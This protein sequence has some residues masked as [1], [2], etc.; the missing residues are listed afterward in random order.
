MIGSIFHRA[1]NQIFLTAIFCI[2]VVSCVKE[3]VVGEPV[4][5]IPLEVPGKASLLLPENNTACE[6]GEVI[7]NKASVTFSWETGE[8]TEVF[9]LYITNSDTEQVTSRT[10]LATTTA[11]V[12]LVRGHHYSWSVTSMNK[13]L[14]V[15][16]S[17]TYKFY[18]ASDGEENGAPFTAEAVFPSPGSSINIPTNGK[19]VLEWDAA[20]PDNDP[21]TYTLLIDTIDG[22]QGASEENSNL[23][24]R[25]KEI[26]VETGK[27]YYWSI[28]TNDGNIKVNSDIFSFRVK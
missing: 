15:T 10:S 24:E 23:N 26:D 19:I 4:E 21:L 16:E 12:P 2:L 25:F 6:T 11:T 13:G 18:L 3:N 7:G 28:I 27:I 9:D 14:E 22:K 8:N 5:E 20:D 17:D 1:F